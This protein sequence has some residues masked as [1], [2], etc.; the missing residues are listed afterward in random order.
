MRIATIVISLLDAIGWAFVAFATFLS[1]SDPATK[2]LDDAA[3]MIVTALFL[4][5]AAPAL[6]LG[7]LDRAPRL[8]LSLAL[9]FPA[10]V[11][12]LTLAAVVALP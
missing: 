5:T 11:I 8:A 10:A 7:V 12:L 6:V 4:A 9:A 1:G 2:G 3:G